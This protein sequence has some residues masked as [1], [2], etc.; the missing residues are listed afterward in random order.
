MCIYIYIYR[1]ICRHES[2]LQFME[3]HLPNAT[4]LTHGFFKSGEHCSNVL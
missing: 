2:L 3:N 4:C 1:Y